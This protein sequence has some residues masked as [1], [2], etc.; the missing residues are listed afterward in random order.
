[1]KRVSLSFGFFFNSTPKQQFA[2][3]RNKIDDG[4]E[5]EPNSEVPEHKPNEPV[6]AKTLL[7]ARNN[8]SVK[9]ESFFFGGGGRGEVHYFRQARAHYKGT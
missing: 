5:S 8:R 1:M 9:G 3:S 7:A 2:A 4:R 6:D